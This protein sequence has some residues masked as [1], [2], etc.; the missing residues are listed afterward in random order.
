M[1]FWFESFDIHMNKQTTYHDF[2]GFVCD[3][4]PFLAHWILTTFEG[5]N[6][7][8]IFL[9]VLWHTMEWKKFEFLF[10]NLLWCVKE[11]KSSIV[12]LSNLQIKYQLNNTIGN[13]K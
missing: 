11:W 2:H 13:A 7:F 4:M 5:I 6:E 8:I 3:P 1:N 9:L 10:W 12:K